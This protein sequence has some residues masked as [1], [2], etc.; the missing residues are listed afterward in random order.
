MARRIY[1][2]F[3]FRWRYLRAFTTHEQTRLEKLEACDSN[4]ILDMSFRQY[5]APYPYVRSFSVD[6]PSDIQLVEQ[7]MLSDELWPLYR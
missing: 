1:G 3:A 5:I 6:S 2:I 4:R 7:H